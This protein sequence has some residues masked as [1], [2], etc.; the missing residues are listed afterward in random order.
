MASLLRRAVGLV[1]AYAIALQAML[2]G[3]LTTAHAVADPFSIIC[4]GDNPGD[5]DG[6]PQH[7]GHDCG[8]CVLTCGS[9]VPLPPSDG[10]VFPLALLS[11]VR[12]LTLSFEAPRSPSRHEPHASRA[13][14]SS[15]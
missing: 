10:T 6:L 8:A 4:A 1:A 13:P 11:R 14:P 5:P 15:V 3:V 2:S 7:E 12:H 9:T